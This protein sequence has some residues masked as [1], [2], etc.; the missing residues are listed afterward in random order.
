LLVAIF[1]SINLS[2]FFDLLWLRLVIN[3]LIFIRV[4][5]FKGDA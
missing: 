4:L 5:V 1:S 3:L 2:S